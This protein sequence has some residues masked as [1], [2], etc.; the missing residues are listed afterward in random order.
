MLISGWDL[1]IML[2]PLHMDFVYFITN[3]D[4][5]VFLKEHPDRSSATCMRAAFLFVFSN[6]FHIFRV[7]EKK[8]GKIKKT[9][10][11]LRVEVFRVF[12]CPSS[13]FC[14]WSKH[15]S[16]LIFSWILRSCSTLLKAS[17]N[18]TLY[19]ERKQVEMRWGGSLVKDELNH[20]QNSSTSV[21][22]IEK[23]FITGSLPDMLAVCHL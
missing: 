8:K 20:S 14:S 9:L 7:P 10:C 3:L 21:K 5:Y 6:Y 4:Y 13:T 2:N 12:Y 22:L 19:K 17:I 1:I 15:T 23:V 16:G 18:V 11:L